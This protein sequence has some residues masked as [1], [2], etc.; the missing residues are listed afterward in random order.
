V[1]AIVGVLVD[2]A[3][4]P[5]GTGFIPFDEVSGVL[6]DT[7]DAARWPARRIGE[8]RHRSSPG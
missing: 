6:A 2:P 8:I 4:T 1:R 5:D 3:R 7:L